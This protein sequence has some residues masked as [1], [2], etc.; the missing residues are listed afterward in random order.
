MVPKMVPESSLCS[1]LVLSSVAR[2]GAR[3]SDDPAKLRPVDRDDLRHTLEFALSFD[4]KKKFRHAEGLA[5]RITADHLARHLERCGYV[6]MQR[7][8]V[9]DFA[10]VLTGASTKKDGP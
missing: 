7:P 4:G 6:I 2:Y 3:M 5:A 8:P 10:H 1:H 9:G